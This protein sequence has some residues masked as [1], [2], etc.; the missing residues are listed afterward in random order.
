MLGAGRTEL[1]RAIFCA[2]SFDHGEIYLEG[3]AITAPSPQ[4]M[5]AMGS[6]LYPRKL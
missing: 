3:Q 6:G 5:S 2:E 4:K 1:L